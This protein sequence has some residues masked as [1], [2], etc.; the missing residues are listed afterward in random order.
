[1]HCIDNYLVHIGLTPNQ[2]KMK[3]KFES[4]KQVFKSVG[5]RGCEKFM[6]SVAT[7]S[8]SV[9]TPGY[10]KWDNIFSM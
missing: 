3:L 4:D 5:F 1:M 7:D 9:K 10:D 8:N 2:T 6:E